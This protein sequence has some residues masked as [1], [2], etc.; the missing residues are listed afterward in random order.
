MTADGPTKPI[1][2]PSVAIDHLLDARWNLSAIRDSTLPGLPLHASMVSAL[3]ATDSAL[4]IVR[5]LAG[6]KRE[7]A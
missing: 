2:D 4:S 6:A 5:A 1:M 3:S 7:A